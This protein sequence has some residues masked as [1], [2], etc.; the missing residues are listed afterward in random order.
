MT[1]LRLITTSPVAFAR[2]SV[3][4]F[5]LAYLLPAGAD[6]PIPPQGFAYVPEL[7][8]PDADPSEGMEWTRL[9]TTT[10]YGWQETAIPEDTSHHEQP[11][12]RIRVVAKVTPHGGGT[13]MEACLASIDAI[14]DPAE[15]A[16]AE[17]CFLGG[18]T[19]RIDSDLL[20]SMAA[21]L[22]LSDADL[23]NLFQ[24]AASIVV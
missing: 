11:A 2:K 3:N 4:G 22:G 13:L 10:E 12:W 1:T 19:L 23:D 15:K 7:D 20:V 5:P 8:F 18:N 21:G 6:A 9:L 24:Q 14:V 17:E 16:A